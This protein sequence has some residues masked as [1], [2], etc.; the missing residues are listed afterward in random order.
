MR[1]PVRGKSIALHA[2]AAYIGAYTGKEVVR[3][4]HDIRTR[5]VMVG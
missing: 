1:G 3:S 5:E 4:M 2:G